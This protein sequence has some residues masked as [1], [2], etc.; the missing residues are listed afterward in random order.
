MAE[1]N[2]HLNKLLS[3]PVYFS[4]LC[5]G[6]LFRGEMYLKPEDLMPVKGSQR[7][8]YADQVQIQEKELRQAGR[9]PSGDGFLSGVGPKLRLEPV[10]T[11]VLYWGSG[12]W[13]GSTSLHELLGL[14]DGKGEAPELAGYIPD[15]R[16][17][18][19]N[20][21]NMDDPSIFRTQYAKI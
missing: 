4:D 16:L 7:V 1:Q 8:L 21:A 20:A 12:H 6:V 3:D 2:L 10:V 17:N 14:K 9:R 11:L 18:L 15:Y 19:V 13:D 5:N